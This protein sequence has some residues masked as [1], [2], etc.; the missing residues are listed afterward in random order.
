MGLDAVSCPQAMISRPLIAGPLAGLFFGDPVSG[1][2]VGVILEILTLRQLP[3]GAARHWDSGPAAVVAAASVAQ[4]PAG[5]AG[6]VVGV[7]LGVLVAWVGGWTVYVMRGLNAGLV[8]SL[9]DRPTSPSRLVRR[10]LTAMAVDFVRA[11]SL[12]LLMVWMV[13]RLAASV[14]SFPE[15]ARWMGA[16]VLLVAACLAVGVDLRTMARG[17]VVWAAFAAGAAV[18]SALWLGLD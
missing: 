17:R 4:L 12:T 16:S 15:S 6:L 3:V 11:G 10:H 13:A 14:T 9:G 2:W 5:P 18:S 1:M 7:G 8:G